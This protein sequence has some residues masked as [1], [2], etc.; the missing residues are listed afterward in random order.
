MSKLIYRSG[1]YR[2]IY[3][4]CFAGAYLLLAAYMLSGDDTGSDSSAGVWKLLTGL[5]IFA[6]AGAATGPGLHRLA[7]KNK[8]RRPY[9]N[10]SKGRSQK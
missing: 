7:V 4:V 3:A 5:V 9:R 10:Q 8:N 6:V 1:V 2:G